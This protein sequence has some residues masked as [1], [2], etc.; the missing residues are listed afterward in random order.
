MLDGLIRA[1]CVYMKITPETLVGMAKNVEQV[2]YSIDARLTAIDE[3]T[4]RI[5]T[6]LG[7]VVEPA[8]PGNV[9]ALSDKREM[10]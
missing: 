6:H 4:A 10:K 9:V 8:K 3:R 5:E 2:V 7:I 1:L